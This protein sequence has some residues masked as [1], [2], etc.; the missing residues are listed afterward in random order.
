MSGQNPYQVHST[1][2]LLRFN[3]PITTIQLI[4]PILFPLGATFLANELLWAVYP[5][6]TNNAHDVLEV[7]DYALIYEECDSNRLPSKVPMNRVNV[8]QLPDAHDFGGGST[9]NDTRN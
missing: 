8:M 9:R 1:R 2:V 4:L 7:L 3:P 6:Y 5:P